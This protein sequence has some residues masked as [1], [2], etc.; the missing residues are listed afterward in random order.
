MGA[1]TKLFKKP[2]AKAVVDKVNEEIG[3]KAAAGGVPKAVIA[4]RNA[5]TAAIIGRTTRARSR[6]RSSL[7]SEDR[8][9]TLG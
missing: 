2:A 5:G 7:I 3:T 8:S 6:G 9:K 4:K 1:I